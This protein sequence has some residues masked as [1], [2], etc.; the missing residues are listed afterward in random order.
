MLRGDRTEPCCQFF[1][2]ASNL[3]CAQRNLG[4]RRATA[5]VNN[6]YPRRGMDN[7]DILLS[8][9]GREGS[10]ESIDVCGRGR[11]AGGRAMAPTKGGTALVGGQRS[12]WA[13]C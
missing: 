10:E 1:L 8:A 12:G 2:T 9:K 11:V 13:P 4:S 5:D 3:N 6:F 7:G